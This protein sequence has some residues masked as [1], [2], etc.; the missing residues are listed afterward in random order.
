MGP[1]CPQHADAGHRQLQ[2]L[3]FLQAVGHRFAQY[4][5]RATH[6]RALR[7]EISAEVLDL[8][9]R[10]RGAEKALATWKLLTQYLVKRGQQRVTLLVRTNTDTEVV[11]DTGFIE[12]AINKAN[13]SKL[14]GINQGDIIRIEFYD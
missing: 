2:F 10:E 13:A 7:Q 1:G 11:V 8:P 14:F 4:A 6:L 5:H 12:I 3:E 9:G